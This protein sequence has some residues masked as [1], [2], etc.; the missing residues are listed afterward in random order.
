L[1]EEKD[2]DAAMERMVR[3]W[4]KDGV[5]DGKNH[6]LLC[7]TNA[8]RAAINRLAQT[9]MRAAGRLG[10]KSV[11]L[12]GETFH[13]GDRIA[14]TMNSSFYQ[15]SN[16]DMGT[17]QRIGLKR[18]R[19]STFH[20]KQFSSLYSML[21][22]AE[23][24]RANS[25]LWMTVKL[26]SGKVVD[27]PMERYQNLRLG[28]ALNS[29]Q[30]QGA[31]VTNC[32]CLLNPTVLSRESIYVSASRAKESTTFYTTGIAKPELIRKASISRAKR[33]AHDVLDNQQG[34]EPDRGHTR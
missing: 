10:R 29:Y 32:Y 27:L 16:G 4:A 33:M 5:R 17:V 12:N 31:T 30:A 7:S 34:H 18:L 6:L 26:D 20:G 14:F 24:V 22:Y 19:W 9:Q 8:E 3:D 15:V 13:K 21:K 2:A 1:H 11:T 25:G 28:Y 23:K